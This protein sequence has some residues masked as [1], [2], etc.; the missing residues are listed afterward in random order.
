V[1]K[2][3]ALTQQ[4]YIDDSELEEDGAADLLLDDNA[5]ASMPRPGTSLSR[6]NTKSSASGGDAGLRPMSSSGRPLSGFA[7]PGT[8][9]RPVTGSM[10][11]DRALQGNRP[12]TSRPATTF[13]RQVRLGTA[14]MQ[15]QDSGVF[16]DIN[17]LDFKKYAARPAIAKVQINFFC[18]SISSQ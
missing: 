1:T 3:R 6:P 7:R 15:S 14:S 5:M 18:L 11:V 9:S 13:G 4:A 16:I 10:S 8:S 2:T 12:G 17:R